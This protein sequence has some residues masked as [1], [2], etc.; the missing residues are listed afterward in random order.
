MPS[1]ETT[2]AESVWD[3]PRPP[4][5]HRDPRRIVVECAG[6][7]LADTTGALKIM[8]TSHPPVFYVPPGDVRTDLLRAASHHAWCEWKGRAAFW[9]ILVGS[10]IRALA[11]WSYSDPRPPYEDLV[12]HF[13]FYA[14]RVD[15]CTVDGHAVRPQEGDFYGG[16][17]TPE[18]R[19]PFKGGAHTHGW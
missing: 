9:D 15:R 16:W 5:L 3:Y 13:A 10:D 14:G 12:D 19:G 4:A 2:P 18:V 11:A 7:I 6:Q 1:H 8:E 17:I